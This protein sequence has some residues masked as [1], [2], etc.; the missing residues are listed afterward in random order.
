MIYSNLSARKCQSQSRKRNLHKPLTQL[1]RKLSIWNSLARQSMKQTQSNKV[2]IK[3]EA[4]KG[5][6]SGR[7]FREFPF[8]KSYFGMLTNRNWSCWQRTQLRNTRSTIVIT[9]RNHPNINNVMVTKYWWTSTQVN[10]AE[11]EGVQAGN[12]GVGKSRMSCCKS[13]LVILEWIIFNH[14][15]LYKI[16]NETLR[17]ITCQVNW[18]WA[19]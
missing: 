11:P 1:K 12:W 4:Q 9:I 16:L 10:I 17:E 8:P 3:W 15:G 6:Q 14:F 2:W 5:F 13:I 19:L 18:A 7:R